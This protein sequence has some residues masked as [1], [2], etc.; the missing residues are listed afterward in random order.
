LR[1]LVVI[2][3][4]LAV[5][6]G[7]A[8][9]YAA[10][11]GINT[12]TATV[13]ASPNKAGSA[14]APSAIGFTETYTANGTGG[15]R[16]APLTDIK[17][18]LYGVVSN[19][20]NFPTCSLTKIENAKSDA[21]CP[22]GALIASG[23]ITATLG[24]VADTSTTAPGQL[25]CNPLLHVWNAG[26]GKV[27]FF[28]VETAANSCAGGAITT[29]DV[30]PY[31]GTVKIVGKNLVLDTPIPS[32]VSF[33]INGVEGSLTSLT[34]HYKKL[35]GKSGAYQAST[36][37]KSGKR[38]YSVAFTAETAPGATPVTQTVTGTQKCS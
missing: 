29:G 5:L 27:V 34:L 15:S 37:C 11:S 6:V 19:G 9:A 12:Y 25:P 24:P 8:A 35:T 18:T 16:T 33:P 32:Y 3:T 2:A 14:K 22:K 4:A 30:G 28:F 26:Q 17:T 13:K 31:T 36:A 38:P 10:T 20:K 23:S 21:G 1:R 7:A